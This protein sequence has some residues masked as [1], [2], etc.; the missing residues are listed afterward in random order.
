MHPGRTRLEA[1]R[2][3]GPPFPVPR[4]LRVG[5]IGAGGFARSMIFPILN[6]RRASSS[7][8]SPPAQ[9]SWRRARARASSS[10]APRS[11]TELIEDPNIDAA[12]IITRH[13]S[14]AHT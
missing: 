1:G 5:C 9:V 11:P 6:R 4:E 2:E 10:I 7:N 13:D 8:P 12:F 14:H 3:V